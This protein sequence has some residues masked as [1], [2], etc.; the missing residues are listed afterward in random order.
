MDVLEEKESPSELQIL[1]GKS[2][3]I[4]NIQEEYG[5]M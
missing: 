2:H 4:I 1:S 3:Y 5:S